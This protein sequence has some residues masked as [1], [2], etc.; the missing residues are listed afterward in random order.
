MATGRAG[1]EWSCICCDK[2][3]C[4]RVCFRRLFSQVEQ[5]QR[6]A[7]HRKLQVPL[8]KDVADRKTRTLYIHTSNER[9]TVAPFCLQHTDARPRRTLNERETRITAFFVATLK[10]NFGM[11][12]A[13]KIRIENAL[14]QQTGCRDIHRQTPRNTFGNVCQA[15]APSQG[16]PGWRSGFSIR[17]L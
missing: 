8:V 17:L 1:L 7:L 6:S 4:R 14:T 15:S 2:C 3:F 9:S 16:S 10:S 5:S 12:C 11:V 13:A